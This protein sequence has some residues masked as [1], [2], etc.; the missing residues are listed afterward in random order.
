MIRVAIVRHA[1]RILPPKWSGVGPIEPSYLR[2][3][4]VLFP[5]D[6]AEETPS[7]GVSWTA[8]AATQLRFSE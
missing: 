7:A 6:P 2:Y 5:L 8:R 3:I 1:N 4:D